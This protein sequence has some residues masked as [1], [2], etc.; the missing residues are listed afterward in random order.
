VGGLPFHLKETDLRL[1]LEDRFGRVQHVAIKRNPA[2]DKYA[3][4]AF[5][6]ADDADRATHEG[7]LLTT[8]MKAM[9]LKWSFKRSNELDQSTASSNDQHGRGG[10]GKGKV[11]Q[12]AGANSEVRPGQFSAVIPPVGRG[13]RAAD[14]KQLL[15]REENE[16]RQAV[17][18]KPNEADKFSS[19]LT[20]KEAA[21]VKVKENTSWVNKSN[22]SMSWVGIENKQLRRRCED[23]ERK[24]SESKKADDQQTAFNDVLRTLRPALAERRRAAGGK[25]LAE[26][27]ADI[28]ATMEAA[29]RLFESSPTK[30]HEKFKKG[31]NFYRTF[32]DG[33]EDHDE[34]MLAGAKQA[35]CKALA[36]TTDQYLAQMAPAAEE[37]AGRLKEINEGLKQLRDIDPSVKNAS[38]KPYVK[39]EV[40]LDVKLGSSV[41][42]LSQAS[43]EAERSLITA[44]EA[45][46]DALKRPWTEKPSPPANMGQAIQSARSK[47]RE[48]LEGWAREEITPEE[49]ATLK[50]YYGHL[51]WFHQRLEVALSN[52]DEAYKVAEKMKEEYNVDV[53]SLATARK[54]EILMSKK[55]GGVQALSFVL[56]ESA[57]ASE[58][59]TSVNVKKS[60]VE[61]KE[62]SLPESTEGEEKEKAEVKCGDEEDLSAVIEYSDEDDNLLVVDGDKSGSQP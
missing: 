45:T 6:D 24:L 40:S 23:L 46:L 21:E 14:R 57:S 15:L 18:R 31:L 10:R 19:K 2:G 29:S 5:E 25:V 33:A 27:L 48:E 59:A 42:A 51:A 28:W 13:Q 30:A 49:R 43:D 58:S 7:V 17:L 26:A 44:L 47:M 36:V 22:S 16:K 1:L 12:H 56:K 35:T 62:V 60:S 55:E 52:Y 37:M 34:E 20:E 8:D 4:A 39:G 61:E 3:F 54:L 41:T 11:S 50:Q 53:P 38:P 9:P 32:D